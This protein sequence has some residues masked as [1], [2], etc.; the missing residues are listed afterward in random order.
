[1]N[2]YLELSTQYSQAMLIASSWPGR[3]MFRKS[4]VLGEAGC[5]H[6]KDPDSRHTQRK[7]T[8]RSERSPTCTG[9]QAGRSL[10]QAGAW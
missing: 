6:N 1:M 7:L 4:F 10:Q 3:C 5:M 8:G 2:L 9:W